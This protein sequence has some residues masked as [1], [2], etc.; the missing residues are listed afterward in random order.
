MAVPTHGS[1]GVGKCAGAIAD[2]NAVGTAIT[3][4]PAPRG[5]ARSHAG[6][7]SRYGGAMAHKTGF[8]G[9]VHAHAGEYRLDHTL[10]MPFAR[11]LSTISPTVFGCFG[12]EF[13]AF[14]EFPVHRLF[15]LGLHSRAV[16]EFD[17]A[18]Y[19]VVERG[20]AGNVPFGESGRRCATKGCF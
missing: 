18:V 3:G 16:V 12:G 17:D 15:G 7:I 13:L 14:V 9:F 1:M 8:N 6:F 10:G 11:I 20:G 4:I 19:E 2:V 5:C